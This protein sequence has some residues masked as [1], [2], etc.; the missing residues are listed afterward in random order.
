MFG[1]GLVK[2][3]EGIPAL[4]DSSEAISMEKVE[5]DDDFSSVV[6]A[7]TPD[8]DGDTGATEPP[9]KDLEVEAPYSAESMM[10]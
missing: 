1:E 4:E 2:R 5:E 8:G 10:L 6:T 3:S 9:L 7:A